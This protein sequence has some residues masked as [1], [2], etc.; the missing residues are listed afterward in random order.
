M[1]LNSL[2]SSATFISLQKRCR[3]ILLSMNEMLLL[4]FT[5]YFAFLKVIGLSQ[6]RSELIIIAKGIFNVTREQLIWLQCTYF[7]QLVDTVF[8]HLNNNAYLTGRLS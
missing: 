7:L 8:N 3:S 1:T 5:L 4:T 2:D 6:A